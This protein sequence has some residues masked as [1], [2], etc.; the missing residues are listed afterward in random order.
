MTY[1]LI[2]DK[3]QV[4]DDFVPEVVRSEE[5]QRASQ[6]KDPL[7]DG[8]AR[9]VGWSDVPIDSPTPKVGQSC[10]YQRGPQS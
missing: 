6:S 7:T 5:H 3:C 8:P 10:G 9:K 2:N 1:T 4:R